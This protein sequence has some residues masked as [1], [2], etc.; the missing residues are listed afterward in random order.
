MK[1]QKIL[2]E[3][4]KKLE[5]QIQ[6]IS[7][8]VSPISF[9]D[10]LTAIMDRNARKHLCEKHPKC[11]MPINIGSKEIPFLPI[12]SRSGAADKRMIAFSMK[13]CRKLNSREYINQ[14]MLEITLKKLERLHSKYS[15]DP[16]KPYKMAA[17][18]G[19]VSKSLK[20]L[21]R[22]I[23]DIGNKI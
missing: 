1:N 18:K 5:E 22:N 2:E 4:F 19:N 8:I 10:E 14:G 17:Q 6:K 15:K 13:L 20:I 21:K 11:W 23:Q 9:R 16:V 12:C 3:S 7:D